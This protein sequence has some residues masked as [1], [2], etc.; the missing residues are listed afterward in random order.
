MVVRNAS[1]ANMPVAKNS[2]TLTNGARGSM[3][4]YRTTKRLVIVLLAVFTL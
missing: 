3:G 4:V 1:P 2:T